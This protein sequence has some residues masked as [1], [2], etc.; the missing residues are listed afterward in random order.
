MLTFRDVTPFLVRL[1]YIPGRNHC[2]EAA[3]WFHWRRPRTFRGDLN[4]RNITYAEPRQAFDS[5]QI[6][7]G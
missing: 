3:I 7:N 5:H 2:R 4:K 1:W 6:A